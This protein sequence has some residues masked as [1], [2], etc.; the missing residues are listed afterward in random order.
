[1]DLHY[2]SVHFFFAFDYKLSIAYTRKFRGTQNFD[3]HSCKNEGVIREGTHVEL[4]KDVPPYDAGERGIVITIRG[5]YQHEM[6]AVVDFGRTPVPIAL[7]KLKEQY[8]N[9]ILQN[10]RT[11]RPR[12]R[13]KN[14]QS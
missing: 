4:K 6:I 10:I 2:F 14:E 5:E 7:G 13:K 11:D 3:L 8:N 12:I 9:V 1:M